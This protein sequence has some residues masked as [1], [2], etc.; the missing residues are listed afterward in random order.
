MNNKYH[1]FI[2]CLAICIA[3]SAC[4]Y[5][6]NGSNIDNKAASDNFASEQDQ[7]EHDD[8]GTKG[9]K[10]DTSVLEGLSK[11]LHSIGI[12]DCWV[13]YDSSGNISV[14][15]ESADGSSHFGMNAKSGISKYGAFIAKNVFEN[16]DDVEKVWS[17]INFNTN[18]HSLY[19]VRK[20]NYLQPGGLVD[21]P[22]DAKQFEDDTRIWRHISDEQFLLDKL[23]MQT[24]GKYD[25]K[26]AIK[27]TMSQLLGERL[28]DVQIEEPVIGLIEVT[29]TID[30]LPEDK[31]VQEEASELFAAGLGRF[32]RNLL[33]DHIYF[34]SVEYRD[35][36]QKDIFS[37]HMNREFEYAEWLKT[38]LSPDALV[39]CA[40]VYVS[41]P[42][43]NILLESENE[44]VYKKD[45]L[46]DPGYDSVLERIREYKGVK[47][48]ILGYDGKTYN[49]LLILEHSSDE[50]DFRA[51]MDSSLDAMKL[52]FE[53]IWFITKDQNGYPKSMAFIDRE[54]FNIL[55]YRKNADND[56]FDFPPLEWPIVATVFGEIPD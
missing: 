15:V 37:M 49:A 2:I 26:A 41:D 5:K 53:S 19:S 13:G 42:D 12:T 14:W 10:F 27:R 30:G 40:G 6:E 28:A 25:P 34:M 51:E 22:A 35:E 48:F 9:A 29:V 50:E 21:A 17:M 18:S 46:N 3:L 32:T 31:T 39:K 56:V 38:G 4:V 45:D 16:T 52:P 23:E 44:T 7:A 47:D 20:E 8:V 43:Y 36:Q 55:Q 1:A 24:G 54:K 11:Q 33:F